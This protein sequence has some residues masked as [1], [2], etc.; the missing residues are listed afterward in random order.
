MSL[1]VLTDADDP[2]SAWSSQRSIHDVQTI[3]A[4]VQAIWQPTAL[5]FDPIQVETVAVPAEV[6]EAIA[7]SGDTAMFFEQVGQAFDVPE[8]GLING[9][10]VANAAGV[11]G[12]TPIG[13]TVFFV[14][15]EP[16][17]HDERV[18]SHEIGHILGLRHATDDPDRLMF[19]GTNGMTLTGQEEEIARYGAEGLA[20]G[21][22]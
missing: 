15:D 20:D 13:S 7:G 11:N 4:G 6:L 8:P 10:Y 1:Y 14:V 18:T 9:F 17:V 3:A 12:F 2:D 19:S 5:R 22:R 16:S 21:T